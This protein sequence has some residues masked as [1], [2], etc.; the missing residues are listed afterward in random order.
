MEDEFLWFY[1]SDNNPTANDNQAEWTSYEKDNENI[2][3]AYQRFL[4]ALES[5]DQNE[6][7]ELSN[8]NLNEQYQINFLH[9]VQMYGDK[10]RLIGRFC[11]NIKE[12]KQLK[13][14]LS[15]KIYRWYLSS[16]DNSP[17]WTPFRI[18]ENDK[19]ETQFK[20]F[21]LSKGSNIYEGQYFKIDFNLFSMTYLNDLKTVKVSR[22]N[23]SVVN[24]V[25]NETNKKVSEITTISEKTIKSI[26]KEYF[27]NF[28]NIFPLKILYEQQVKFYWKQESNS[29]IVRIYQKINEDASNPV[30]DL[31]IQDGF[32]EMCELIKTKDT[33]EFE[34]KFKIKIPFQ[35]MGRVSKSNWYYKYNEGSDEFWQQFSKEENIDLD[36]AYKK[37]FLQHHENKISYGIGNK[38]KLIEFNKN[39]YYSFNENGIFSK[40]T[41]LR[42]Y[43]K[44]SNPDEITRITVPEEV[45]TKMQKE[46]MTDSPIL[47]AN[48]LGPKTFNE[49]INEIKKELKNESVYLNDVSLNN[50]YEEKYLN[51]IN[52]KNFPNTII[53]I[54][55]EEGFVY[56]RVNK[57]LRDKQYDAFWNFKYYYFSLLY[58]LEKIQSQRT[59]LI[60]LYRGL[61][62]KPEQQEFYLK[63]LKESDMILFN[64]FLSTTSDK[65]VALNY[66]K[67]DG[68]L[69]EIEVSKEAAKRIANIENFS[70]FSHEKEVLLSSG[71]ILKYIGKSERQDNL[72]AK[73]MFS[74]LESNSKAFFNFISSYEENTIDLSKL[75]LDYPSIEGSF[76]GANNNSNINRLLITINDSSLLY[77]VAKSIM[78]SKSLNYIQIKKKG[79]MN[80]NKMI[81][82]N[83]ERTINLKRTITIEII[84]F[85]ENDYKLFL[86]EIL[87]Q[88][89]V[90]SYFKAKEIYESA[91]DLFINKQKN[92][93]TLNYLQL[94]RISNDSSDDDICLTNMNFTSLKNLGQMISFN[95]NLT[96]LKLN[97]NNSEE[98][99]II[100]DSLINNSSIKKIKLTH[101]EQFLTRYRINIKK[102]NHFLKIDLIDFD[103]EN[104]EIFESRSYKEKR[105]KIKILFIIS[106]NV[107][108]LKA[109]FKYI[110]K[111]NE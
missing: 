111:N 108:N 73:I 35:L 86:N 28:K 102:N 8:Y 54:Y 78:E 37:R 49:L 71:S 47:Y 41:I 42:F 51:N 61:S 43:P 48:K 59:T 66:A 5:E 55:T 72:P 100:T 40:K 21:S 75:N 52:Q 22:K 12:N 29:I 87:E 95:K 70:A 19:I 23:D 62:L 63:N 84:N 34:V 9:N 44:Y 97:L 7:K 25:T 69:F 90:I 17:V 56:R 74:L 6:I 39:E 4:F 11:G 82:I 33:N 50:I 16:N 57:V 105:T 65:A 99:K 26:Q 53:K 93:N 92:L 104:F 77:L 67:S 31:L 46:T 80:N 3:I 109:P 32:Q 64:E 68:L 96:I 1:R 10:Q 2:E 76:Q 27:L 38:R 83:F 18:D 103:T 89:A 15:S 101:N 20:K 98:L 88:N 79:E 91:F 30:L 36:F 45:F 58:S 60:N 107:I 85:Y 24:E 14:L 81:T 106:L 94:Y 13:N 110:V